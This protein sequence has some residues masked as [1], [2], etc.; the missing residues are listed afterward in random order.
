MTPGRD[1]HNVLKFE[2]HGV[3][4]AQKYSRVES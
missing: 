4:K 2:R 1:R 3:H